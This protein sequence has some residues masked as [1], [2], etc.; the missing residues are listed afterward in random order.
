MRRL[1]IAVL[2]VLFAF[3]TAFP[4]I[5]L[6]PGTE[7][8][9][10]QP[11]APWEDDPGMFDRYSET[12]VVSGEPIKH[13]VADL[14]NDSRLDLAVVY[15]N[16]PR[17]DIIYSDVEG[18][19]NY[20]D[21]TSVYMP[22][23]VTDIASGDMNKDLKY[24]LVVV[25]NATD[26]VND[27]F[28]LS[29]ANGFSVASPLYSVNIPSIPRALVTQ[30]FNVDGWMDIAVLYHDEPPDY[31][32]SFM[33]LINAGLEGGYSPSSS[34]PLYNNPLNMQ[35]PTML[36]SGD[37]HQDG[38]GRS[39]LVI[40]DRVTGKV[41]GFVNG[42][43]S[44]KVWTTM[45]NVITANNPS[46]LHMARLVADGD[47]NLMV[48]EEGT[49]IINIWRYASGTFNPRTDVRQQA[50]ITSMTT[51]DINGDSRLDLVATS[52][53]DHNLTVFRAG[54]TLLYT[55]SDSLTFPTPY[56]PVNVVPR[57]MNSDGNID[58]VVSARSSSGHGSITIYYGG[59]QGLSNADHNLQ[60]RDI[61]PT[62]ASTGDFN[63]DGRKELV[64]YE[65]GGP[66]LSFINETSASL[67]RVSAPAA[68]LA[69]EV[70]DLNGD[71][72]ED[73]IM[74]SASNITIY[75]GDANVFDQVY[76][77]RRVTVNATL[78]PL[79]SLLVADLNNDG[80]T[81]VAV[82]GQGG[83]QAF[84]SSGTGDL[85]S[86][87]QRYTLPL[88]GASVT[89]LAALSVNCTGYND[90]RTDLAIINNTASRMEIY[91]QQ[92]GMNPFTKTA[93]NYLN[94]VPGLFSCGEGTWTPM[95]GRSGG[96]FSWQG[97]H[98]PAGPGLF[99]RF[100]GNSVCGGDRGPRGPPAAPIGGP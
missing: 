46:A 5:A 74:M 4:V 33:V 50:S 91:Y 70:A 2:I 88:P 42:A 56:H 77:P 49:S 92:N 32:P 15:L 18:A 11:L 43:T 93:S 51:L 64:A 31:L 39:D 29:Q 13:V 30:D 75:F 16:S 27:L 23:L 45:T 6:I 66:T 69:M 57:D 86:D 9:G 7:D 89:G 94:G 100:L 40:G 37:F 84:W 25:C 55:R 73:V 90:A 60:V 48:A 12:F 68:V 20:S 1:A 71:N 82:G 61:V 8:V 76:Q 10:E 34:F 35:R 24:D 38:S 21:R 83:V 85:Y 97:A 62:L 80:R 59:G 78:L 65:S 47:M 72:R 98:L 44:G 52:A 22:G 81:D 67:R 28:V 58:L 19:F 3:S 36:I 54:P 96:P 63:G 26:S 41:V 99:P 17:I 14:N 87:A 95:L 53:A 79:A